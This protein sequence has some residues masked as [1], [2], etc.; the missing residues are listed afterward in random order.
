MEG[1]DF[2]TNGQIL[3]QTLLIQNKKYKPRGLPDDLAKE[4]DNS[5]SLKMAFETAQAIFE[6]MRSNSN[7]LKKD[8]GLRGRVSVAPLTKMGLAIASKS[9]GAVVITPL[10]KSFLKGTIDLGDLFFNFLIKWQIPTPGSKDFGDRSIYNIKPFLGIIRLISEVN[11]LVIEAGDKAVG[12]SKREFAL[13]GQTL[14]NDK[15]IKSYA[16]QIVALRKAMFKIP[17]NDKDAY[18]N[19]Y[20]TRYAEE[21]F[22]TTQTSEVEK[23]LKNLKDYADNSIRYFRLTRYLYIRGNGYYIDLEHR[24]STEIKEML[25][26]NSGA[27]EFVDSQGYLQYLGDTS[28]PSLPWKSVDKLV[29]IVRATERDVSD[30]EKRLNYSE[31]VFCDYDEYDENK[32]SKY[33]DVLRLYR[34]RL[35]ELDNAGLSSSPD[36]ISNYIDQLRKIDSLDNR[37]I[38]LE[39]YVTLGL[40]ALNDALNIQPNYPVGDD[41][42]PTH[43]APANVP[44]IEC[45]YRSANAICEVT[46]L[47]NRSQWINEGQPVMRHLRDF[48]DKHNDKQTYGVFIAPVLHRDTINTYWTSVKFEYEGKKQ[49]IIPLRV[50]DFIKILETL[51]YLKHESRSMGHERLLELYDLIIDKSADVDISTEWAGSIPKIVESWSEQMTEK[52]SVHL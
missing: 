22:E 40:H 32:L 4:Y 25:N 33:V 17:K 41:N 46:M 26:M 12:I 36:K 35:Q 49:K 18:M 9:T 11:Q 5:S 29:S 31:D 1:K 27:K 28:Q 51:L 38:M 47:K 37:P 6:H 24:R 44:D 8:P 34:R 3:Y 42:E 20:R 15:D 52:E 39:K 19:E 2:D 50:T 45:F 16:D 43:T 21:F 14:I 23:S 13:F 30:I 10:G 48:E 7:E